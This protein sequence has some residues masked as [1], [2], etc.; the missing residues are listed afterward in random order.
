MA[1]LNQKL[2]SV[3]GSSKMQYETQEDLDMNADYIVSFG[4]SPIAKEERNNEDG[5]I[6][7]IYKV[8]PTLHELI[9][10]KQ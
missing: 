8:K 4:V 10:K 6:D 3:Q 2:I 5:T 9:I 7:L 1:I